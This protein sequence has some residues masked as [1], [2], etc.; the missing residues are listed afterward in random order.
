[1]IFANHIV[2]VYESIRNIIR[3]RPPQNNQNQR[4]Q[5][6]GNSNATIGSSMDTSDGGNGVMPNIV[7]TGNM[8][9]PTTSDSNSGS[10]V[11]VLGT[12]CI[13]TPLMEETSPLFVEMLIKFYM[14][15]KTYSK[16]KK[17]LR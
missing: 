3:H 1:M 7:S 2:G 9:P 8:L 13:I 5:I 10:E 16:L 11:M 14:N 6:V 17:G 12:C 15:L 4:P